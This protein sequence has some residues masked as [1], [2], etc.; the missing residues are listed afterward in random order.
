MTH[1]PI[2][3]HLRNLYRTLAGLCGAYILLFGIIGFVQTGGLDMFAQEGLPSVLGIRANR[4]FAIIS[5]VAG[6][7]IIAG[8]VIGKNLDHFINIG[9]GVLF[10][11]AGMTMMTL[12]QTNLNFLGFTMTTCIVSF[13]IGMTLFAAGLYGKTGT[14]KQAAAE[15]RF[16]HGATPDPEEHTWQYDGPEKPE[17]E[18]AN[19]RF[20]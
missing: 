1:I 7:I 10:L 11:L 12:M 2:N 3:H 8:A 5:I 9:G 17:S 6:L 18:Q 14:G 13:I 15:E 19:Q 4:G 20:A 16:R